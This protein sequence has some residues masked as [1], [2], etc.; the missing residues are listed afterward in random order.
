MCHPMDKKTSPGPV[1]EILEAVNHANS[2]QNPETLKHQSFPYTSESMGKNMGE[3]R[4]YK[5]AANRG[6]K[7]SRVFASRNYPL[8]SSDSTVR[9]LRSRSV[10]EKSPSDSVHT[11]IE[12]AAEKPPSDPVHTLVRPAAKKN[13][14]G[15]PTKKSSDNEFSKIRQRVRYILNRMN[16]EQSLLEAYASEGW[17]RQRFVASLFMHLI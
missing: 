12:K 8:R 9:V 3:R 13:K 5:R 16:Y 17:K 2:S 1:E 6:R 14:K 7:E 11:L 10:E 15:K 4:N